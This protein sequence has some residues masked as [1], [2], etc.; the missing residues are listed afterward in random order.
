MGALGYGLWRRRLGRLARMP[1]DFRAYWIRRARRLGDL[2][3]VALGNSLAQGLTAR[4]PTRSGSA[5]SSESCAPHSRPVRPGRRPPGL[6]PQRA[7][8][9]GYAQICRAVLAEFPA[10]VPVRVE[11]V[12]RAM[13]LTELGVDLVHPGDRGHRRYAAEAPTQWAGSADSVCWERRLAGGQSP[14]SPG[15]QS[16]DLPGS[17]AP[18]RGG[19]VCWERRLSV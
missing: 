2:R 7:V 18:T 1:E 6:G 15:G 10:L 17:R 14:D 9:A 4:G 16:A 3:Y 19:S 5:A 11:Q 13:R 12:T 8:A